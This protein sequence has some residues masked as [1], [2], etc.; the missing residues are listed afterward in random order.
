MIGIGDENK[1][2][3]CLQ[4]LIFMTLLLT[5]CLLFLEAFSAIHE[6]VTLSQF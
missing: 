6:H 4:L 1:E 5:F 2:N 3:F